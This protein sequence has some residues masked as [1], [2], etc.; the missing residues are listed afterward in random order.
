VRGDRK[1]RWRAGA[2]RW[3]VPVLMAAAALPAA[4]AA[5]S[6]AAATTSTAAA[7]GAAARGPAN[8]PWKAV[9]LP[10]PANAAPSGSNS[11]AAVACASRHR[12]AATGYY[13]D[14]S[15]NQQGLLVTGAASAWKAAAAPLPSNAAPNPRTA[16]NYV[17]CPGR[18][19]CVAAGVYHDSSGAQQGLLLTSGRPSWQA[20]EAP[21]PA[22]AAPVPQVRLTGVTCP[23]TTQCVAI[24][25]YLT[26]GG[27]VQSMLVTGFGQH[28]TATQAPL[29]AG[30][31]ATATTNL[32]SVACSAVSDCV[33]VGS[34]SP[35][36]RFPRGL[37]VTG[38]GSSWSAHA[39]PLP[40]GAQQADGDLLSSVACPSA[41]TCVAVGNYAATALTSEGLVVSGLDASW[42]A[43]Q[44]PVPAGASPQ[45][46][47]ELTR[48][49]CPTVRHCT[50]AGDYLDSSNNDQPELVTGAG[51]SWAAVQATLPTDAN[52][53]D[54][55]IG[56]GGVACYAARACAAVGTYADQSDNWHGLLLTSSR[57]RWRAAAAPMPPGAPAQSVDSAPQMVWVSCPS[58][59]RCVGV[60]HYFNYVTGQF[61]GMLEE[62][63]A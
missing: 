13:T 60:G 46:Q 15:G 52:A 11:L 30:A 23:S 54:A 63:P 51:P 55:L 27:S 16:V 12:C 32:S 37:I 58:A 29:P 33:A 50:A 5:Q 4:G 20:V 2:G 31:P 7:R 25:T 18:A 34:Y 8:K 48:L 1:A 17:A 14:S 41:T 6:A 53:A 3:L 19:T 35:S 43:T 22:G 57:T 44:A 39:V 40:A 59:T 61:A 56:F 28:W 49:A 36:L 24:G 38:S 47:A 9:G 21:V 45:P 42:T 26:I 62:G 10:L